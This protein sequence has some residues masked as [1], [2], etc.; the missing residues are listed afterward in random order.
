MARAVTDRAFERRLAALANNREHGGALAGGRRGLEREG[1]RVTPAGRV[2]A[3]AQPRA[4]GSALCNPH[5]TTDYSEALLELV[6]PTFTANGALA[7]YLD[8]LHHFVACQLD[9]ELLWAASMPGEIA[10]E[11]EVPIAQYGSSHRGHFKEVYRRGLQTRYGGLMQAIAGA[12]YN[13][14]FPERFWPLWADLLGSH[15][16]DG[17]FVSARYFD[18]VR[19]YRRH[20]WLALYLFGVSPALCASFVS[21]ENAA[22][23]QPLGPG[24]LH[25]PHATSLRMSDLGYRNRDQSAVAVSVNSLAEYLRDLQ[26]ATHTV[27][28]PFAALGLCVDGQYRQLNANILQIENEYYSN[29][30]PKRAPQAGEST[31]RALARGGVEYVEVR[32]LDICIFEPTGICTDQMHFMEAFLALCL[33]RSSDPISGPEQE[34]LDHNHLLV[35]RRGREPDLQLQRDGRAVSLKA[36]GAELLDQLGGICELLDA[37]D[38]AQSY[39]RALAKQLEKLRDPER[40]PSALHLQELRRS[41]SGFASYTLAL[42]AQHRG[43]LLDVNGR[44]PSVQAEFA[45]EAAASLLEQETVERADR[46]SFAEYLARTLAPAPP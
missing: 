43:R 25:M 44:D 7:R 9:D 6:T 26:H 36:W 32:A 8:E 2:A 14:S 37:G 3:S 29:I 21:E 15:R 31:M 28:P 10:G 35:A 23:M 5:I 13:Y 46:G 17:E 20:G 38:P 34:Q 42:S 39:R 24:T 30:R 27:H 22:E 12:H 16:H 11:S 1:L 33:A 41:G 45:A 19:N 18:L 40:T 4:L